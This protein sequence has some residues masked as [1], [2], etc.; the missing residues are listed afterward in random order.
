M[1]GRTFC[2][3]SMWAFCFRNAHLVVPV[4]PLPGAVGET[5]ERRIRKFRAEAYASGVN[6]GGVHVW[7]TFKILR[8]NEIAKGVV[9][10]R[11]ENDAMFI[12]LD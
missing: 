7:V 1:E 4:R 10:N 12:N 11:S 8:K 9:E 5:L 3:E 2:K 6:F